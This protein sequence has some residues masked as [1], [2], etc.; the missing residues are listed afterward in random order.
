MSLVRT[1]E[2]PSLRAAA[3]CQRR[4]VRTCESGA[5]HVGESEVPSAAPSQVATTR[6]AESSSTRLARG[7]PGDLPGTPR[8]RA[9]SRRRRHRPGRTAWLR[10]AG[11]AGA[12]RR[13][14][15]TGSSA[16]RLG[17]TRVAV[18]PAD[19]PGGF[20][21]A[22]QIVT[23]NAPMLMDSVTVL[24]HRLG[25][26]YT[27]IMNPVFRVRRGPTGELLDD[28]AG[29]RDA[30]VPA[31]ASTRPGSTSSCAGRSTD[32]A[33]AEAERLLPER[34]R[35]RPPGRARLDRDGGDAA[36]P[37]RRTRQRRRAAG[38]PAPTA[39]TSPRCCAGWPTG[40][41]CCWATSAARSATARRPVDPSSRL[42]VL[43]LR[44]RR[45]AAADRQ[46]R[47]AGAGAGHHPQLPALR[48]LPVHRGGPRT[49][50][51]RR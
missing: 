7:L 39:R 5:S 14:L 13:A 38:S 12:G 35:R 28:R 2:P 17:D 33:L 42:G 43:R 32:E 31:T 46:R 48:R 45:A 29:H 44:Q 50:G 47:P 30:D 4:P 41:S 36:R 3:T 18:Y 22:L 15:P 9:R 20:G 34:A 26:A 6:P 25:V 23:D 40:T 16:Q 49:V 21:P 24:L 11:V 10:Q 8:R 1:T 27:A 51:A 19:D 37:G